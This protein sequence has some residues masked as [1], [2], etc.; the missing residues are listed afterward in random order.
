MSPEQASAG[1]VDARSDQYSLATVLY[2]MLTGEPPFSGSTA[3]AIMAR[4]ISEPAR[5]VRTVRPTVPPAVEEAVLRALERVPADRYADVT[6]FVAAFR[7]GRAG[8]TVPR[9]V[10]RILLGVGTLTRLAWRT[11]S[12]QTGRTS[13]TYGARGQGA[14]RSRQARL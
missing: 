13:R 9:G 8:R 2:E 11:C 6:G 14:L 3:Q 4:R 7:G 10:L 5:P 12:R 1:A